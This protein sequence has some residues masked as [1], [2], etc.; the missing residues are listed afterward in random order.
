MQGKALEIAPGI[1]RPI[2]SGGSPWVIGA[3]GARA[4]TG[5]TGRKLLIALAAAAIYAGVFG[6][7][8]RRRSTACRSRWSPARSSPPP[9]TCRRARRSSVQIPGLPAPVQNRGPR[10]VATPTPVRRCPPAGAAQLDVPKVELPDP[11]QAREAGGGPGKG[12]GGSNRR[13]QRREQRRWGARAPSTAPTGNVRTGTGRAKDKVDA[14]P[15]PRPRRTRTA[16]RRRRTR[17]HALDARRRRRSASRTSSST[18]SGSRRS[19]CRST[20]PPASS[21]ACAGRSWP[22]STRSRPTTAATSTCPPPAPSAGCSSCPRPGSAYGVD[23]N[24]DGVKDPYNPVDAIF[25]AARYLRAAGA[26][27]DLRQAVFAYNHADWYVDSVLLRAR[28][29]G[30]L[31][32]NLVGSLTGLTQGHFPVG[33]RPPTRASS[34]ARASASARATRRGRRADRPPRHR[35]LLARGRARDR[36]Q[37]RADH[38][39]SARR[40]ARPLRPAPGRLR[41]HVHVRAPRQ[42]RQAL[43]VA[44]A[45]DV[46][47]RDRARARSC[48][49][50][51]PRPTRRRPRPPA[52]QPPRRSASSPTAPRRRPQAPRPRSRRRRPR[53]AKERLFANPSAPNASPA[54]GAQQELERTAPQRLETFEG[55]FRRVFGLNRKDD[56]AQAP[57]AGR[58]RRRRHDPRPPRPRGSRRART[59]C[60][61]SARPAAAPR[62]STRSRSSTAGSCSSPPRSTAPR[63]RTRSSAPTPPTRRSARSC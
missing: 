44:Q 59:C 20:R 32:S 54:G 53:A 4:L 8:L 46:T 33:A 23:A 3:A 21:T 63:A 38:R 11:G 12:G 26:D 15:R 7:P 41:Q 37:R 13:R 30:G 52:R 2:A 42:R 28:V 5:M 14:T 40:A 43:P 18:S 57:E 6:R 51:T 35:H 17:P 50:P 55:Y 56:H 22:R 48:R 45:A 29:L 61:R 60:S 24:G 47:R 34:S 36:G 19:C 25:A 27:T 9:S 58:A 10:P 39:R 16:P 62:A 1:M 49:S 31:P